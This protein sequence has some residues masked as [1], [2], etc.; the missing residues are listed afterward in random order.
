MTL[1]FQNVKIFQGE[2][3][4][5]RPEVPKKNGGALNFVESNYPLQFAKTLQP[6]RIHEK[7]IFTLNMF[8]YV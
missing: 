5:I 2:I 4:K 6:K 1:E 3:Q 7:K 8:E